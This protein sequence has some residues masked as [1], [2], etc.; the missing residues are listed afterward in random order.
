V[1]VFCGVPVAQSLPHQ[2]PSNVTGLAARLAAQG[3]TL[4]V[5]SGKKRRLARVVR[6]PEAIGRPVVLHHEKLEE[7]LN[8]RPRNEISRRLAVYI[9]R[10]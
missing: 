2:P 10:P 5:I 6:H 7:S 9:A 1:H 3:R 8:H 4:Y